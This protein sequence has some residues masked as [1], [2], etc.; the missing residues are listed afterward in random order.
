MTDA[1]LVVG[2]S[3]SRRDGS[4]TLKGIKLALAAAEAEGAETDLI[5]LG[6]V[7]LPLYH[8]D[9]DAAD[10]GDAVDLLARV[11]AAD[12]VVVG[13]PVYHASYSSTFRN[14]HDYCG[15]DEYEDTVV[16]LLVVAGG[17]TIASTLDHMRVTM[18]GVH[19]H[20]IPGQVGV[21][22]ASSKFEADGTMID[23]DIAD[24]IDALAEDV[25][26][27]AR[28]RMAARDQ[29]ETASVDD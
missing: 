22:N 26:E 24:R 18:R 23:S 19:A 20:V 12:A 3:G 9:R 17:G 16:G 8:P 14:F 27:E 28:I 21:R 7:D 6:D 4:H 2:V 5:D 13:S 1:P 11:R 10:S 25:V 29:T 15:F